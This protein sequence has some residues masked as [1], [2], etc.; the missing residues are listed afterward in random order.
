MR[1]G[2]QQGYDFQ[3]ELFGGYC[4]KVHRPRV[5]KL[6]L[7]SEVV[8]RLGPLV[9]AARAEIVLIGFFG[10]MACLLKDPS[11][12][13]GG[14]KKSCTELVVLAQA[15]PASGPAYHYKATTLIKY[16]RNVKRR[17]EEECG[18]SFGGGYVP[19]LVKLPRVCKGIVAHRDERTMERLAVTPQH[20]LAIAD[21]IG[22]VLRRDSSWGH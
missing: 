3:W 18:L 1:T 4:S 2:T 22:I 11:I 17:I 7:A 5:D 13:P 6:L 16:F 10:W 8:Q 12:A 14:R 9:A 21:H 15:Q 19:S 20:L